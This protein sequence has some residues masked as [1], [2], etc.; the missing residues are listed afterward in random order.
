VSVGG[1]QETRGD[2][3]APLDVGRGLRGRVNAPGRDLMKTHNAWAWVPQRG[4]RGS[5]GS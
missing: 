1:G 2:F 5:V 4:P 3:G